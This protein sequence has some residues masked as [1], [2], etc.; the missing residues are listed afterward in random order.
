[1]RRE[2]ISNSLLLMPSAR[3]LL[4]GAVVAF[5]TFALLGTASALWENRFFVRM[6][7]VGGWELGL[8]GATSLLLGLY[9]AVKRVA[10][11]TATAGF[12]GLL[13]F[14][15][16]ACPIC[17][18]VLL[19]VFGSELLLAYFE[20]IRV[21]AAAVGAAAV[22]LAVIYELRQIRSIKVSSALDRG[23]QFPVRP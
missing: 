11:S 19:F 12:G 7:P 14:L 10:C 23:K 5:V 15:G 18:K 3:R 20:P 16:V 2:V 8:L 17:N 1:M 9:V 22:G 13:S 4:A 6:T 21:Y